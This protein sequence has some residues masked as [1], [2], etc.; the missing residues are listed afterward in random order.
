MADNFKVDK[1][2][3]ED[4]KIV[5]ANKILNSFDY[6]KVNTEKGNGKIKSIHYEGTIYFNVKEKK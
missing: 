2:I 4:E 6:I 1:N 5:L 3:S